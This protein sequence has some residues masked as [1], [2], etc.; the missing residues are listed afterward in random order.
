M[1]EQVCA[2]EPDPGVG[3]VLDLLSAL[4]D[5]SLVIV[6]AEVGG[7]AGTGC[8]TPSGNCPPSARGRRRVARAAHRAPGLHARAGRLTSPGAPSCGA[9]RPGPSGSRCTC[10]CWP[11]GPTSSSRSRT[12][13]QHGDADAGLRLCNALSSI[14]LANGDVSD[15]AAWIDELLAGT[16]ATPVPAGLRARALAVA[17]GAGVRTAGLRGRGPVRRRRPRAQ[18]GLR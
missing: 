14:W 11:T 17:L 12:A 5:K 18:P 15:G 10:G 8:S 2:D 16:P 1:A 3:D 7:A 6:D 4:I 9:S 13:S